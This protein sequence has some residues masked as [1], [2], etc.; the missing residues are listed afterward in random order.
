MIT[1]E[2]R[3]RL[4]WLELDVERSCVLCTVRAETE[5]SESVFSVRYGLKLQNKLNTAVDEINAWFPS[6][7]KNRPIKQAVGCGVNIKT[8]L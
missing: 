3:P 1:S 4:P 5:P 7:I 8:G 6:R 2:V